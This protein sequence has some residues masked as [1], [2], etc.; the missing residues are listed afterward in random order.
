MHEVGLPNPGEIINAYP[1]HLSGGMQ[2]RVMI[3]MALASE[4]ELLI[5]DEPTTA[6]DVTI[7]AQ[8][9]S[10]LTTLSER[11]RVAVLLITH[12]MG[13][14]AATCKRVAVLYAGRVV[15]EGPVTTVF[16]QPYHPYTRGLLA[17]LPEPE[18]R[19]QDLPVILGSVPSGLEALPGC[20]FAPRCDS[21]LPACKDTAPP[22]V[23]FEPS[24][25]TECHLYDSEGR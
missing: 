24:H 5:A 7:Q 1:H 2:Q 21:A 14:V 4:P 17:S 13:V 19:S 18:K 23:R 6:L 9:L 11:H 20:A 16:S 12:D 8:I 22:E 3:A 25:R 15:E 10:L